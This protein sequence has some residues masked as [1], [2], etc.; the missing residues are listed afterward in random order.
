M[1][2]GLLLIRVVSLTSYRPL[3]VVACICSQTVC[4]HFSVSVLSNLK[5]QEAA[6]SHEG[7]PHHVSVRLSKF[8]AGIGQEP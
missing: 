6:R 5:I 7:R 1:A 3:K 2:A 4:Q 8:T